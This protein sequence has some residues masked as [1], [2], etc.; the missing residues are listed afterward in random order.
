MSWLAFALA[1]AGVA[2]F[3]LAM[4]AHQNTHRA[5]FGHAADSRQCRAFRCGGT[6]L[7]LAAALAATHAFGWQVGLVAWCAMLTASGFTLTQLLAYAP[8]FTFAPA[9]GLLVSA[10][11]VSIFS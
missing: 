11:L 8:R 7:L 5:L 9:G 4:K 2:L 1:Y 3:A 6:A 10:L